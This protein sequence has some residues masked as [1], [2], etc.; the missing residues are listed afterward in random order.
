MCPN[1]RLVHNDIQGCRNSIFPVLFSL[2]RQN[3]NEDCLA[4]THTKVS[5]GR[6]VGS[7]PGVGWLTDQSIDAPEGSEIEVCRGDHSVRSAE[8][9]FR[10][11]FQLSGWALMAFLYFKD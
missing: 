8:K 6:V 2:V 11:H 5:F 7:S 10:L 3:A 1:P 4:P 9:F